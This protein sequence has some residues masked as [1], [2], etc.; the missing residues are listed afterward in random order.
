MNTKP[1]LFVAS[2]A[3]LAACSSEKEGASESNADS[4]AVAEAS[5]EQIWATDSTLQTPES[6]LYDGTNQILYVSQIN[7]QPDG[8]DGKGGIAKVGPDGKIIDP[9]WITGLSAPKGM[10]M[11]GDQLYVTDLTDLV[12]IDIPSGKIVK[13][14]PVEDAVFL[15]DISVDKQGAVYFTDMRAG[16]IHMLKDG[17]VTTVL[18]SLN[19]P[20]GILAVEDGLLFTESGMLQKLDAQNNK[21]TLAQGM[22]AS[23]DGIE[24]V[25]PGEFIVSSWAGEV[26]HVKPDGTTTT[27]LDTK[28]SQTNSADIGYDAAKKIVYVPTFF[29][30]SVVAYQLK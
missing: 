16:K 3:L 26:Y 20:N 4:T 27:L 28:S 24:Q 30:N 21:T 9:N 12:Q 14:T 11:A 7:G 23:T 19:N 10:G 1:Y 8:K 6:V 15:N 5:L 17:Q 13:K 2:L 18:D 25:A 29:K 22:H